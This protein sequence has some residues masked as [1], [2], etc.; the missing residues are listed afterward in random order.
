MNWYNTQ[1]SEFLREAQRRELDAHLKWYAKTEGVTLPGGGVDGLGVTGRSL[2]STGG[3]TIGSPGSSLNASGSLVHRPHTT[4][5]VRAWMSCRTRMPPPLKNTRLRH[6]P[7][8]RSVKKKKKTFGKQL[9]R[10]RRVVY[11]MMIT[12]RSAIKTFRERLCSRAFLL[13]QCRRPLA[14]PLD[15]TPS[16]RTWSPS[17]PPR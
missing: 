9:H 8:P 10:F 12:R 14:F 15:R 16:G 6:I 3:S 2:S 5:M 7:S 1:K 4:Y 17:T 13:V 11:C